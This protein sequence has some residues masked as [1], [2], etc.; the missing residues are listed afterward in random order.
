MLKKARMMHKSLVN[1]FYDSQA[2]FL[3]MKCFVVQ[4]YF[5][6]SYLNQII[7]INISILCDYFFQKVWF[8]GPLIAAIESCDGVGD[9]SFDFEKDT[10]ALRWWLLLCLLSRVEI[11]NFCNKPFFLNVSVPYPPSCLSCVIWANIMS[12]VYSLK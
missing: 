8:S 2:K 7:I 1:N 11:E 9:S 4:K 6:L 10:E 12:H 3:V 5:K